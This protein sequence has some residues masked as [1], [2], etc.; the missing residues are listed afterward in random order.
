MTR[1]FLNGRPKVDGQNGPSIK[2]PPP[3]A[4]MPLSSSPM[5][6]TMAAGIHPAKLSHD[7]SAPRRPRGALCPWAI[8]L[9]QPPPPSAVGDSLQPDFSPHAK[10]MS[11]R[12]DARLQLEAI[13]AREQAGYQ[14]HHHHPGHHHGDGIT[15]R[16]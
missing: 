5:A 16:K 3:S 7:T 12:G 8:P 10:D 14:N 13:S 2:S 9:H 4:S 1:G 11:P 15:S 6:A